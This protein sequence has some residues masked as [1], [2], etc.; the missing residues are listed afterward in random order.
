MISLDNTNYSWQNETLTIYQY[1]QTKNI[2]LPCF[3]YHERLTIAG[4]CRMCLVEVNGALVVSCAMPLADRMHILTNSQR[5]LHSRETVLEFLLINHP[6]DCPICDQGGECDL[7]DITLVF[8][9]D[10]G[11]FYSEKRSVDNLNCF[12]PL[13]KTIMTRCIHCTRC[14]RF[15]TEYTDT[16]DLGVVGRGNSMEIGTYIE[17]II[18]DELSG[19][20]IDLCPVGALTSMPYTFTTR[21]W[22]LKSIES[23]DVLDAMASSIRIDVANNAVM[24]ILPVLMET[25]NE[26][27]ITNK[28]RFAFDAVS[29]QRHYY[30]KLNIEGV[31]L[32][33]SW[34][35]A[36]DVYWAAL[37]A[38]N[39]SKV[40]AICGKYTDL[41]TAK[42]IKNLFNSIG[43]NTLSYE[44]SKYRHF[45]FRCTYLLNTAISE[46]ENVSAVI[47]INC[48]L[49][50]EN[51]LLNS[52]IRKNYL[53]SQIPIF[54]V[55]N[56]LTYS[57]YPIINVGNSITSLL[58]F[59]KGKYYHFGSLSFTNS[60]IPYRP[61]PIVIFGSCLFDRMDATAIVAAVIDLTKTTIFKSAKLLNLAPAN[62]G[63]ISCAEEGFSANINFNKKAANFIHH[64]GTEYIMQKNEQGFNVY[65]GYQLPENSN[66]LDLYLPVATPFER[67]ATY[68][69]I[70]GRL[71]QT[72]IAVSAPQS[73]LT[74]DELLKLLFI[75]KN[76]KY[77]NNF[78]ILPEFYNTMLFF[79][80]VL[81]Y[82]PKTNQRQLTPQVPYLINLVKTKHLLRFIGSTIFNKNSQNYYNSDLVSKSSK[83][84]AL[85][86][87][88]IKFST[89]S[90]KLPY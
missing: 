78:S 52:R 16:F 72:K 2:T 79:K 56:A 42:T 1:C 18:D 25:L 39:Y 60:F 26:D 24:R 15:L 57:T 80:K 51:P 82:I 69:N 17:T 89:F 37:K 86:S 8:G 44:K 49:R 35:K 75:T 9:M 11:R 85:F 66:N 12:G 62:L 61:N 73:V 45:D 7:Q 38:L 46:L 53:K 70:E 23:V 58:R 22:E 84:M 48:D 29:I 20:I 54:S 28:T 10:R 36:M 67:V 81:N 13:I 47:L 31:W 88:K 63:F 83:S 55:G 77:K 59:M 33:C 32:T 4:N 68:V 21:P 5:L 19:N 27:W 90:K 76:R 87:S 34:A 14:V 43:S 64:V 65:Q 30:P 3:C 50:V 74:D 41:E 40:A 71:R 6:L